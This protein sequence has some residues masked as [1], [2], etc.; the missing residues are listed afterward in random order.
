[1]KRILMIMACLTGFL[2]A[3]SA[4]DRPSSY[5]QLPAEARTFVESNYKDVKVMYVTK[6]DDFFRPDY[7][8]MLTNGILLE[9]SHSGALKKIEAKKGTVPAGLIPEAIR[10]F[11]EMHYP[12]A[13]YVEYEI[14][15]KSYEVK[16]SNRLELKFN[17]AFHIIEVDD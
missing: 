2:F 16:L 11:V 9:F 4:D 8:V 15:R 14:G 7:N 3:A 13:D 1:M 10:E 6:E 12:S 5:D 17:S